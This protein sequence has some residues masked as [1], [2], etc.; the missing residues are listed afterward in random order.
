MTPAELRDEL[1]DD[2]EDMGYAAHLPSGVDRIVGLLNHDKRFA[3]IRERFVTE[4]TVL[5]EAGGAGSVAQDA[6]KAFGDGDG[7]NDIQ[8]VAELRSAARRASRRIETS[9]TGIDIGHATTQLMLDALV[10][11]G[12][13]TETQAGS[14]KAM[15]VQPASR[16]EV[17]SGK[18]N[19]Y[20]TAAQV[21]AAIAL[22]EPPE[23][24]PSEPEE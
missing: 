3:M 4:L 18:P 20:V 9:S 13:L 15:G 19:A 2:P 17:L 22:I 11:V 8:A 7:S 12:A 16:Y 10:Q 14:L 6:I 5:A 1:V 21:R 23:D 24:P